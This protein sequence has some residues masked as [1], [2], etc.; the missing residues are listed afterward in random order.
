MKYVHIH[1]VINHLALYLCLFYAGIKAYKF[2]Q[3]QEILP[4]T[5]LGVQLLLAILLWILNFSGH[6]A[7]HQIASYLQ[8]PDGSFMHNHEEWGELA[9]QW[10]MLNLLIH[11]LA[12]K[13]SWAKKLTWF[14]LSI[15]LIFIFI[16]S[17]W[18]GQLAHPEI[19]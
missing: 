7:E 15:L 14:S 3:K 5:A 18:G 2:Y 10:A 9:V 11:G 17:Y 1:L 13:F 4:R 6:Q 16:T 19:R 8:D 12:L